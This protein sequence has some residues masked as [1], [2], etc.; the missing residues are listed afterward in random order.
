MVDKK[1]IF[2]A[3]TLSDFKS[4]DLINVRDSFQCDSLY[5]YYAFFYLRDVVIKR[6]ALPVL[7]KS[8]C[9]YVKS[10]LLDY[11]YT[12]SWYDSVISGSPTGVA[13]RAR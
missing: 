5:R 4:D 3:H 2:Y 13:M 10:R 8:D 11:T 12:K 7:S 6:F 1:V 9:N